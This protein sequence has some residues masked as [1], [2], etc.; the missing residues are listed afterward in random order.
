MRLSSSGTTVL[1]SAPHIAYFTTNFSIR[2]LCKFKY[3]VIY[4]IVPKHL[5][6]TVILTG[7][8]ASIVTISDLLCVPM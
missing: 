2:I 5:A 6:L 1:I 3:A 8:V 7:G 4:I